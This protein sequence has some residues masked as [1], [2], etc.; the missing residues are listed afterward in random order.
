MLQ[1]APGHSLFVTHGVPTLAPPLHRLPPHTVA[2]TA[3]QSA[4]D[5]Q[6]VPAKLLQVSQ[7]HLSVVYPEA[8]QFGLADVNVIDCVPV[9]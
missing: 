8:V 9:V 3:T 2:P 7:K 5:I 6:G 1:A 4:F